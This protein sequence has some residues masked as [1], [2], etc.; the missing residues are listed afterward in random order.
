MVQIT[1]RNFLDRA[2][3][4]SAA[5][6]LFQPGWTV[7]G[8]AASAAGGEARDVSKD[9]AIPSADEFRQARAWF[10]NNFST[11][12]HAT[13]LPPF[14]F[15]F[16][17]KPSG[18]LL[19]VWKWS[20]RRERARGPV[21]RQS[22]VY[23]DPTTGLE[24][25]CEVTAYSD[26][27]AVEW[28]LYFENTGRE[29]TPILE[30]V[31][32]LDTRFRSQ[33]GRF[34]FHWALGSN[35]QPTDF[36]PRDQE[37][38]PGE[39]VSLAPVGGR[40]S[41][42]TALPFFNLEAPAGKVRQGEMERAR[43]G[44]GNLDPGGV[45]MGLGWSGQWSANITREAGTVHADAGMELT[46]LR[47]E[48][49]ERIRTP[50]ILLL[51]WKGSDRLRSQNLLRH[52]LL[53][54]HTPRPGG[55][56]PTLPV[57]ACSWVAFG[58][59]NKVTEK[60]QIAFAS[61]YKRM[62]PIDTFWLD[63]GWFEGGWPNG[64]GNWFAKKDAFPHGL[65]PSSDAVHKMGMR[66]IV[67]FEPER[68]HEGTWL[69]THHP[70]WVLGEG[71]EKLLN[72]GNVAARLWL[73]DHISEMIKADG[74]DI[75]RNDFNMDPLKYWH[76]A[77]APDRQGMTEIRYVEGLY[78]FWDELLRRYP[79]LM[80]DNCSSGGRRIDLETISRSVALWRTDYVLATE[81]APGV[82]A[83]GP[84]LGLWVPLNATAV[85]GMP[86]LYR[87]RSAMGA[88]MAVLWDV[89]HPDFDVALARKI[90]KEE[91][92]IS[93]FYSGDLYP[94]T[95]IS[96]SDNTWF[97]YQC[98]RPDLGEGM[99]MA[100]RREKAPE[101]SWTV[102]LRGVRAE[103][104]YQLEDLDSGKKQVHTGKQLLQ[105]LRLN[106]PEMPGSR[107]IIYRAFK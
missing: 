103:R 19:K 105:D 67:W 98:D 66:F 91:K 42:T 44:R 4:L 30:Q 11:S 50:R 63:A 48:P 32:A 99:V 41:N 49:G 82:Q 88:G 97:A 2:G 58:A 85:P 10:K 78:T 76:G 71:K 29:P 25:R 18:E 28:V 52:F 16:D 51:F 36:A 79:D 89:R 54:H 46:H 13:E 12:G 100:F 34:V 55:S 61:T 68:V 60:N 21:R 101:K 9:V 96:D 15:V 38:E 5:A 75:Y 47:L 95:A 83:Q 8:L 107:L 23:H 27:P 62:M 17:G 86:D 24:L 57:A 1:R 106:I 92:Y 77:D 35:A 20:A 33:G 45:V 22:F 39:H 64:V 102:K 94:L 37:L 70:E 59:G 93:K 80:I 73:T 31:R 69:D 7:A 26:F 90:V 56:P 6:A 40:S 43:N 87:A 53:A 84:G 74:I 104:R 81:A 65:R 3:K 14:S 72:L